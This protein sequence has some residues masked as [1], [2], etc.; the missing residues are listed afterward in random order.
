RRCAAAGKRG[1]FLQYARERAAG[2]H[3]V[4]VKHALLLSDVAAGG[5]AV[6]PEY[7]YLVVDEAHHLEA[8]ATEQLG[9]VARH[10][11][12]VEYLDSLHHTSADRRTGVATELPGS[13]RRSRAAS[14]ARKP[15]PGRPAGAP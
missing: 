14:T 9:Y 12:V 10:R 7:R 8:Q 4:I 15:A 2:A 3:V 5:G 1:C 11:D 13:V 6:I